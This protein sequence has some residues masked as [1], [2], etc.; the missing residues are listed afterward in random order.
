MRSPAEQ[1]HNET[2]DFGEIDAPRERSVLL[3]RS[4]HPPSVSAD[5]MGVTVSSDEP[6]DAEG[7][8]VAGLP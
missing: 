7:C 3:V 1:P 2:V 5:R 6:T 8:R 4:E